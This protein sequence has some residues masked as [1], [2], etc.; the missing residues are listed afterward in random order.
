MNYLQPDNQS[1]FVRAF[2]FQTVL[3]IITFGM[4]IMTYHYIVIPQLTQTIIDQRCP[5]ALEKL[6]I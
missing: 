2:A 6:S 3:Q 5:T 4:A 1:S